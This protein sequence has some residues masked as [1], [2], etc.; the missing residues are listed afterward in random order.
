[1]FR[2]EYLL[3]RSLLQIPNGGLV[4]IPLS[5]LWVLVKLNWFQKAVLVFMLVHHHPTSRVLQ[6]LVAIPRITTSFSVRLI[7]SS[8]KQVAP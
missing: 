2:V 5:K 7:D 6:A 3:S 1:M 4:C 8:E